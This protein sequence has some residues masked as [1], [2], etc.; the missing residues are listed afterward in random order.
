[1]KLVRKNKAWSTFKSLI[2]WKTLIG[3]A[4]NRLEN[5]IA[6][7]RKEFFLFL[8]ISEKIKFKVK[9]LKK[10]QEKFKK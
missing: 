4:K 10:Y 7:F 8:K 9:K 1:M 5:I 2:L 3:K 6:G